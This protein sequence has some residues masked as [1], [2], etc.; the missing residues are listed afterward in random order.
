MR[1][2]IIRREGTTLVVGDIKPTKRQAAFFDACA[3]EDADEI[4][5]GG[6]IRSGKTQASCRQVVHWAWRFGGTH[7][8]ARR[9]YRELEDSTKKVFLRG[10]GAV[11][12]ACPAELI[13][14]YRAAD[15]KVILR[16][17][18]EV[19]FRSLENPKE[20][21]DKIKNITLASFFI[22]QAEELD[23]ND[24]YNLY[25]TMLGRLSDPRGPRKAILVANPGPETHW[26]HTR[27]VDPEL[28]QPY[29]AYIHTTLFDNEEHLPVRYVETQIRRKDSDQEWYD[30][31]VLGKWG[32]FGGKRFKIW[33]PNVHVIE[34]V[35]L[36]KSWEF[37]EG[38]DYGYQNPLCVLWCAITHENRWYMIAEHYE[39]E[40]PISY[41]AGRIKEIREELGISPSAIY[42]DPSAWATERQ[43][44]SAAAEFF[45]YGIWVTKAQNDRIGG[46]NRIDEMLHEKLED[47]LPRLQIF[48]TCKNLIRELPNLKIKDETDD[49]E[50]RLDHAADTARYLCMSRTPAPIRGDA[51]EQVPWRDLYARRRIARALSEREA[52][53][54]G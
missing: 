17:G 28:R 11:P 25:Q 12:A 37:L 1:P 6:A 21:E 19:L 22:D 36:D 54:Y 8:I 13:E 33:N 18:A 39:S 38:I 24:N 34:P 3:R 26:L 42:L 52:I 41:H 27:F 47:G 29:T 53:F 45:D 10:D 4:L 9:T 50:K 23:G 49:V 2:N 32:S 48:N 20:A 15:N 51:E 14:N 7:L 40:R 44:E 16:N 43:Y 5:Y 35:Q 46:W 30:R 31:Y